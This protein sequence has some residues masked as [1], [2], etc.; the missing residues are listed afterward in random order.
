MDAS[1]ALLWGTYFG[2]AYGEA[3]GMDIDPQG[4]L[5]IVGGSTGNI[6]TQSM[7]GA[8]TWTYSGAYDAFWAV[9]G[10]SDE[11]L[12]STYF[13]STAF[14]VASDVR[15]S[16]SGTIYISGETD[17]T[18]PAM[19]GGSGSYYQATSAGATDMFVLELNSALDC[20]WATHL[21][22]SGMDLPGS[23]SLAI[24]LY[25]NVILVGGTT[26]TNFP[27][28]YGP[29]WMDNTT[30][31]DAGI[32]A[33]FSPARELI[34]STYVCGAGEVFFEAAAIDVNN[35]LYVS[36]YTE[37][38]GF[39]LA[40]TG[41]MYY[42]SS[43]L[44]TYPSTIHTGIEMCLMVFAPGDWL[45]HSTYFGSK[46]GIFG[47][48]MITLAW[49]DFLL[50][51]SG[52]SSDE[53]DPFTTIPIWDPGPPAWMQPLYYAPSHMDGF[54]TAF[55]TDMFTSVGVSEASDHGSSEWLSWPVD[56][57]LVVQGL[58]L[59][60]I[61]EVCDVA[62]RVIHRTRISQPLHSVPLPRLASG[63]Y[64]ARTD[65]IGFETQRMVVK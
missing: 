10:T 18:I 65:A 40:Q 29:G 46:E 7:S 49:H 25:N 61:V 38:T 5:I 3:Y 22:G 12:H 34:W 48:N 37:D 43:I 20:N 42:Q 53:G 39:P 30:T 50:Y 23:N 45:A 26:S 55:C 51:G 36:G 47:E 6:P 19:N 63:I 32:I 8:S 44:S 9:F 33:R 24:D 17:G 59:G 54:V 35:N 52:H 1:G 58:P 28:V 62:G 21:G 4:R 56:G 31:G 13:G 11:L 14:D 57:S 16:S 64:L 60:A 41:A 15:V 27:I 2:E